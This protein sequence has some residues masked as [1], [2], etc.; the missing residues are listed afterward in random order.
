MADKVTENP[1]LDNSTHTAT[2]DDASSVGNNELV[3][4]LEVGKKYSITLPNS[5]G[6]ETEYYLGEY[7]KTNTRPTQTFDCTD[8]KG[9]F[10]M[11]KKYSGLSDVVDELLKLV[12]SIRIQLELGKTKEDLMKIIKEHHNRNISLY[13]G[14]TR[15]I[16]LFKTL[17]KL[18]NYV[19]DKESKIFKVIDNGKC[20]N[21]IKDLNKDLIGFKE[22]FLYGYYS[23]INPKEPKKI[24]PKQQENNTTNANGAP[25]NQAA[26]SNLAKLF[27]HNVKKTKG[28]YGGKK[29]KKQRN[30]VN[31][32]RKLKKNKSRKHKK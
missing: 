22:A 21:N 26:Q 24:E 27:G 30:Q 31:K 32:S 6:L 13:E 28:V 15:M 2:T 9:V 23:E 8:A 25:S 17:L 16:E 10:G 5:N 18:A 12:E 4:I 3:S 14:N 19:V 7:K 11:G 20:G 1:D 29:S